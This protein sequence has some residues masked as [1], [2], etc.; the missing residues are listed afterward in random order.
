MTTPAVAA[1]AGIVGTGLQMFG[2]Y[3]DSQAKNQ[4][5]AYNAQLMR[6]NAA[7]AEGNAQ[8]EEQKAAQAREAGRVSEEKFRQ[9]GD[10][11]KGSQRVGYAGSGVV[12]DE[13]SALDVAEDT[14]ELIELDALNIRHNSELDAFDFEMNAYNTRIGAGDLN[15]RA[16]LLESRKSSALLPM[17][18]TGLSGASDFS[19]KYGFKGGK[20]NFRRG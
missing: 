7:V 16:N 6:N 14:T 4:A 13:G 12:V 9:R 5:N 8:I 3:K 15:E 18:A 2:Q 10:L 11:L 17:L 20:I 19:S 1:T